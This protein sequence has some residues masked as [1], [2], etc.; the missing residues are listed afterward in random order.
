[1][2]GRQSSNNNSNKIEKIVQSLFKKIKIHFHDGDGGCG[3]C[4]SIFQKCHYC[5]WNK[6]QDIKEIY[7]KIK[8]NVGRCSCLSS[9]LFL[10]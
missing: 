7:S 10:S 4:K 8:E 6:K 2:S 5:R 1:M 3:C 9:V